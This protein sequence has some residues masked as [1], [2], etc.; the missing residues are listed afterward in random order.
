MPSIGAMLRAEEQ[1]C[2]AP[3]Q[4]TLLLMCHWWYKLCLKQKVT[5]EPYPGEARAV[6]LPRPDKQSP[7]RLPP[8]S[9]PGL[10]VAAA[11]SLEMTW[12]GPRCSALNPVPSKPSAQALQQIRLGGRRGCLAQGTL[13]AL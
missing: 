1:W 12:T 8:E 4:A 9:R 3:K 7:N 13:A 5:K 11:A 2:A 6:P 10:A